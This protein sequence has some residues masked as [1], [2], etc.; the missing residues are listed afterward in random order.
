[1]SAGFPAS[2]KEVKAGDAEA[3]AL[4]LHVQFTLPQYFIHPDSWLLSANIED[5]GNDE[6]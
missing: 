3:I 1:M 4:E 6:I 5:N 2:M